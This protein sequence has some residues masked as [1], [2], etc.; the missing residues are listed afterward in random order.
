MKTLRFLMLTAV[1]ILALVSC[2][3]AP[4]LVTV[5][6][7]DEAGHDRLNPSSEFFIGENISA[8]YEGKVYPVEILVPETKT[9]AAYF[10]GLRLRQMGWKD[11]QYLLEFGE[12]DGADDQNISV[13][14]VWPDGTSDTVHAKH[15]R[16]TP[17]A[18]VNTWRLNGKKVDPPIILVK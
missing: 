6:V 5:Q 2:D 4:V 1:A 11:D 13:T 7:T 9:Y 16:F 3:F 8:V 14:F 18:C 17:L 10:F 12:F 15:T